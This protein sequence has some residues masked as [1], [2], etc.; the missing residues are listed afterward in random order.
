MSE[1]RQSFASS[2]YE[3]HVMRGRATQRAP[4]EEPK[5]RDDVYVDINDIR[6]RKSR[7]KDRKLDAARSKSLPRPRKPQGE[8]GVERRPLHG[9]LRHSYSSEN[10]IDTKDDLPTGSVSK[11]KE[12]LFGEKDACT[13][14]VASAVKSPSSTKVVDIQSK[15]FSASF[16]PPAP[17][18]VDARQ[19]TSYLRTMTSQ[20]TR[21]DVVSCRDA[22]QPRRSRIDDEVG[23]LERTY[24]R[25]QVAADADDYVT[26]RSRRQGVTGAQEEDAEV[27]R[28]SISNLRK[29]EELLLQSRANADVTK[30][31]RDP[32]AANPGLNYARHWLQD[33]KADSEVKAREGS[34]G[35]KEQGFRFKTTTSGTIVKDSDD[36]AFR[37]NHSVAVTSSTHAPVTSQAKWKTRRNQNEEKTEEAVGEG[38]T[39]SGW[40][41]N[42]AIARTKSL[43]RSK[44][45]RRPVQRS[46]SLE[47]GSQQVRAPRKMERGVAQMVGRFSGDATQS[48]PDL[49]NESVFAGVCD[50]L[51]DVQTDPK[52]TMARPR[53]K[54]TPRVVKQRSEFRAKN[55]S[56]SGDSG[57]GIES[58]ESD[59]VSHGSSTDV[60]ARDATTDTNTS[61]HA[62]DDSDEDD[63]R[64]ASATSLREDTQRARA[65]FF[66]T[67][68]PEPVPL[69]NADDAVTSPSRIEEAAERLGRSSH[70]ISVHRSPLTQRKL[71]SGASDVT[72]PQRATVKLTKPHAFRPSAAR[73]DKPAAFAA[74]QPREE[75][76]DFDEKLREARTRLAAEIAPRMRSERQTQPRPRSLDLLSLERKPELDVKTVK[77]DP[78]PQK[79]ASPEP[80]SVSKSVVKLVASPR[81]KMAEERGEDG[82]RADSARG[83][84]VIRVNSKE[85]VE[86]DVKKE[87][88][89][90]SAL[91]AEVTS[92][93]VGE[94][95]VSESR[96]VT[97]RQV[98][99]ASSHV[100][101]T[102]RHV[103][104]SPLT[105]VRHARQASDLSDGEMTDATDITLDAM[106]SANVR[107]ADDLTKAVRVAA[108]PRDVSLEDMARREMEAAPHDDRTHVT[109]TVTEVTSEAV[110][111]RRDVKRDV[112]PERRLSLKERVK[113]FED[114]SDLLFKGPRVDE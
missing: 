98:T 7:A 30:I 62:D 36:M 86:D 95:V 66:T 1:H 59:D 96:T 63:V 46:G 60:T 75:M 72:S 14:K 42:S 64:S 76:R 54:D 17:P 97:K 112:D 3:A 19:V 31:P 114:Q 108:M 69:H 79:K 65:R 29:F 53:R 34:E 58:G 74:P 68:P 28:L 41:K 32:N 106:V 5:T 103:M 111:Y 15:V 77:P 100:T 23:D 107:R 88:E 38:K 92:R 84:R 73:P 48:V 110:T 89:D 49:T 85:E 43:D 83:I 78:K 44:V 2:K 71:R 56:R 24:D 101:C 33:G 35:R 37:K 80:T 109:S 13:F 91:K 93:V 26:S 90:G 20:T 94:R 22:S 113:I 81:S 16:V 50:Q 61:G 8:S 45:N 87:E 11:I 27:K 67:P 70:V 47:R 12:Q 10:L 6:K 99:A 55:K 105:S 39:G 102:T 18:A 104:T 57:F 51:G 4:R 21:R 52:L 40:Q 82:E 25:L 9:I